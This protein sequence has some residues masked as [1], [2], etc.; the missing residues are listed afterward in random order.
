M[1]QRLLQRVRPESDPGLGNKVVSPRSRL[2][3]PDGKFNTRRTGLPWWERATVY[4]WLGQI[5]WAHFTA[6][7]FGAYFVVNTLFALVYLALGEG[8]LNGIRPEGLVHDFEACW[9][10]SAQ[11]LTTVGY[12]HVNPA[13]G[14][15]SGVAALEALI[16]LLGFGVWTG[17]LF[18]R[19]SR[20]RSR[21]LF[22]P[23]SVVT[24]YGDGNAWMFRIVASHDH[25]LLDA[26]ADAIF[27]WVPPGTQVRHY[28]EVVLERP[29][30]R[31]FP[32]NWT[33][34]HAIDE[35]SPL[36]GLILDD[37]EQADVEILVLVKAHDETYGQTVHSR[38]SWKAPEIRFGEKFLPM[39][40]PG[41]DGAVEVDI[42]RLGATEAVRMPV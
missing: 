21:I 39:I 25:P 4:Q 5:S 34:V 24:P 9:F 22:S 12:G 23:V 20:A 29:S 7:A 15:A 18:N 2:I 37:L 6:L 3:R 35:D 13:T 28:Q 33:L 8:H 40:A 31:F 14:V 30:V 38:F 11:T 26:R 16:G 19:F 17:L 42:S 32:M 1:L 27:S 36:S 41:E 10:F